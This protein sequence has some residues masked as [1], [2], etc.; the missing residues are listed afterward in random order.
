MDGRTDLKLEGKR[1]SLK[2]ERKLCDDE[3]QW[4]PGACLTSK[5]IF[6]LIL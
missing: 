6:M 3:V 2:L 4:R 5:Y 1:W